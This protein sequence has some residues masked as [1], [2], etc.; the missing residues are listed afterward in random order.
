[1]AG[2][3]H[4]CAESQSIAALPLGAQLLWHRMVHDEGVDEWGL[5]QGLPG[6]VLARC[7]AG[8]TEFA[9]KDVAEWLDLMEREHLIT[10]YSVDGKPFIATVNHEAYTWRKR[11]SVPTIPMTQ[12]IADTRA[13]RYIRAED[14]KQVAEARVALADYCERYGLVVEFRGETFGD[15]PETTREPHGNRTGT[16]RVPR[17]GAGA[18]QCSEVRCSGVESAPV[19]TAADREPAPTPPDTSTDELPK[20]ARDLVEAVGVTIPEALKLADAAPVQDSG[21][22]PVVYCLAIMRQARKRA[23]TDPKYRDAPGQ[24]ARL[25][26]R[27]ADPAERPHLEA[28]RRMLRPASG[29]A[30]PAEEPVLLHCPACGDRFTAMVLVGVPGS[31]APCRRCGHA[32]ERASGR[33][34]EQAAATT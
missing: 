29:R 20:Q 28:V 32:G 12:E 9:A 8:T 3:S 17:A 25:K 33:Q 10:R 31:T 14:A 2:V 18:V 30:S 34:T 24:L 23:E 26:L 4:R 19:T 1:M 15:Y 13:F 27:K 22:D 11:R 6:M 7:L 21:G 16:E 5:C